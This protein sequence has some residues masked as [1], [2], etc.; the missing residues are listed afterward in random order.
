[1]IN[2]KTRTSIFDDSQALHVIRSHRAPKTPHPKRRRITLALA[3]VLAVGGLTP[4]S[5]GAGM[6]PVQA[7]AS[8]AAEAVSPS[9]V[10]PVR[11][12]TVSRSQR[13]AL[14][15]TQRINKVIAYAM[16]QRGDRYKFGASGPSRW[17]C[18]GLAMVSYR[19]IG[20]KLPHFTGAMLKRGKHISRKN[21]QR[22]DLVFPSNHHVGIYIGNGKIIVA[23]SGHGKVMVQKI[24]SFYAARRII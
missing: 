1:M 24:Y 10:A 9:A 19:Q 2:N 5:E 11:G 3:A 17:D 22:G 14:T 12:S 13:A 18:S 23:S 4:L 8:V 6:A 20:V 21:L 16:A 7:E 15:R